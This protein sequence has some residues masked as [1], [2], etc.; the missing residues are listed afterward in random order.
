MVFIFEMKTQ[1][2]KILNEF[3]ELSLK[4]RLSFREF[5]QEV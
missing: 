2:W 3:I 4:R 1:S 5:F